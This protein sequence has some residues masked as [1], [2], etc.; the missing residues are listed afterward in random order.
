[1]VPFNQSPVSKALQGKINIFSLGPNVDLTTVESFGNEW[2]KFSDFETKEIEVPGQEYFDIVGP[3]ILNKNSVVLDVGCGTGRWTKYI[4]EKAGFV[5]AIDPSEAVYSAAGL[6][7]EYN[8]TRVSVAGV[9][10][11][12][13]DN[14]SFDLVMS[15]GVLHH[16][17][18]TAEAIKDCAKKVK[19]G[20]YFLVYL[21]YSLDTRGGAYKSLFKV[22]NIL[23][24]GISK[25]PKGIKELVCDFIA[26]GIYLPFVAVSKALKAIPGL[27]KVGEKFPLSYYSNKSM[28]IIRNDALDR[29]GTPL[30]QRFSKEQIRQMLMDAGL[31]DVVF[32][33]N[34]PYWHA[35]ARKP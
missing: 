19:R 3:T 16:V 31:T 33:P 28:H 21:Y 18:N 23:R 27:K 17:P 1:M 30:E 22:S 32:S 15:L 4:A 34:A 7:K 12:P 25:L 14:E 6:L 5:E 20:G 29:F 8:N 10:N 35:I 11:I 24:L 13:F 2:T 26:F 9:G